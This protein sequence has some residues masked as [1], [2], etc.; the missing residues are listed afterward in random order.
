MSENNERTKYISVPAAYTL[1][2]VPEDTFMLLND[3][4]LS[5]PVQLVLEVMVANG[6]ARR[7]S[8]VSTI[9]MSEEGYDELM[10]EEGEEGDDSEGNDSPWPEDHE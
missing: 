6:Q 2:E 10:E 3:G 1:Y 7:V 9:T 8:S 5:Q 4:R